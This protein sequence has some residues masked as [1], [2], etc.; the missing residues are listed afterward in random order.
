MKRSLAV[1][2]VSLACVLLATSVHAK[3]ETGYQ[4]ILVQLKAALDIDV[5]GNVSAVSFI[6][7]AKVP[8]ALRREAERLAQSWR[9]QPPRKDGKA[10][11]GR[12]YATLQTCLV[13]SAAGID[14]TFSYAGNGPSGT[15][16]PPRKMH[17]PAMPIDTLMS[18]GVS[19]YGGKITYLVKPDGSVT[20]E[21]AVLDDP[22]LQ[23]RYGQLWSRDQREYMKGFH[24]R[25]ELIDGVAT[26]TRVEATVEQRWAEEGELDKL[27]AEMR[28]DDART[29]ACRKLRGAQDHQ[30]ASDSVFKRIDS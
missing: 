27:D 4:P 6:D 2:A 30:I 12:T 3:E 29:D 26:A 11:S 5:Q 21:K 9:F 25:P 1:R 15:Y 14:Y 13:P 10:V 17:M 18:E 19:R 22:A 23:A 7:E 28:A 20:L 16:R 8:D 24:Y